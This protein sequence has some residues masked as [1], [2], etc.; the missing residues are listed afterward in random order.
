MSAAYDP[1]LAERAHRAAQRLGVAMHA[2]VYVGLHGPSYETPA[3]ILMCGELG[4][5][6][7]VMSTVLEVTAARAR[8][9]RV[10][11][12][13]VITNFGAGLG[14]T[15]LAHEDVLEA[16]RALGADLERV[17]VDVVH[18]LG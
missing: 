4:G 10:L 16:G 6:A 18:S 7:V 1:G 12:F 8:G 15:P 17:V 2:G 9:M 13:S 11:G 5:R 14:L 3:E